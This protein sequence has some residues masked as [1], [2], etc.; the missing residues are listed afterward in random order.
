MSAVPTTVPTAVP[1]LCDVEGHVKHAA[2]GSSYILRWSWQGRRL[3]G[4]MCTAV[5]IRP[6]VH[7]DERAVVLCAHVCGCT[8]YR[9]PLGATSGVAI[10]GRTTLYAGH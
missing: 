1:E 2:V 4:C 8:K 9:T 5:G 7:D 10:G 6:P 3:H